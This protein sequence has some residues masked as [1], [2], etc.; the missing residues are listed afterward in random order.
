MENLEWYPFFY[1]GLE[2]NIEATKF[3]KIRKVKRDWYGKGKGKYLVVYGEINYLKR[4][5]S[6]SGYY[7]IR[8]GV[9]NN[10]G[11]TFYVHQ[12]F[13]SIFLNYTFGN[14]KIVIDHIDSDKLNNSLDNLRIVTIRENCSKEKTIKSGM[15][16]GINFYKATQ[17]YVAKIHYNGKKH[18]IGYFNSIK[19]AEVAYTNKLN[20][21]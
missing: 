9:E 1:N 19:E 11:R 4:A 17:K 2:T 20:S 10:N 5:K 15:P 21:L 18:H 6:N 8:V 13:A 7:Q 3:G 12:I 16:A 14:R